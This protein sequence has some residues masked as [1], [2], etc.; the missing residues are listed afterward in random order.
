M[1]PNIAP[2]S[3]RYPL[4]WIAP[5]FY[6]QFYGG[7]VQI[8][9]GLMRRMKALDITVL[10][11]RQGSPA[12]RI[13]AFDRSAPDERGYAVRRLDRLS[14]HFTRPTLMHKVVQGLSYY[15][16]TRKTFNRCVASV[17]PAIVVNGAVNPSS[18]LLNRL[19]PSI[20][21]VNYIHGEELTQNLVYG[22]VTRM[23]WKEQ[24]RAMATADMNVVSSR[25]T[26]EKVCE[27]VSIPSDRVTVFPCSVDTIRFQ[28][29]ADRE[30]ERSGLGWAGKTVLLTVARLVKRKGIDQTLRALGRLQ[31][32]GDLAGVDWVYVIA[33]RGPEEQNLRELSAQL[34]LGERVRFY[35]F[36][37]D[38]DLARLYGAADVFVQTNREIDGDTEGFGIVFLEANACGTPVIG[39]IA[40]GT[41]DAVEDGRTG[42]RVDGDDLEAISEA[43]RTMIKNESLRGKMGEA[44]MER[45]RSEFDLQACAQKLERLLIGLADARRG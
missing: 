4:L 12:E 17:K 13:D 29:P 44:G 6:P 34:G 7:A 36:V 2:L 31:A 33:G 18:W 42:L 37:P 23:F 26:A 28:P 25:F 3:D 35:G 39:G 11:E 32:A 14:L 5:F 15:H 41:G 9:D 43:L 40:G 16:S 1:K 24:L 21:R 30:G 8:Y 20:V 22:A 10:G 19:P 45:A 38:E 27:L